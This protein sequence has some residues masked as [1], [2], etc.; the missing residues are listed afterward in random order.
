MPETKSK[1][2][3]INNLDKLSNQ[4]ERKFIIE[5]IKSPFRMVI[6][7]PSGGGKTNIISCLL[8]EPYI[9]FDKLYIYSKTIDQPKYNLLKD[10]FKKV[11]KEISKKKKPVKKDKKPLSKLDKYFRDYEDEKDNSDDEEIEPIAIFTDDYKTLPNLTKEIK[12]KNEQTI[13]VLDDCIV[14]LTKDKEFSAYVEKLYIKGRQYN[15]S[16][17]F[18]TQFYVKLPPIIRMNSTHTLVGGLPNMALLNVIANSVP[19]LDYQGWKYVFKT[20]NKNQFDMILI[21]NDEHLLNRKVWI[22]CMNDAVDIENIL[23]N[24]ITLKKNKYDDTN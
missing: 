14:E 19:I 24:H 20:Y 21:N 13:I 9:Y 17:I 12:D 3:I 16:P 1:K 15:I 22:N 6:S 5:Q 11:E 23:R 18:L 7:A 4:E 2:I 10:F 8:M